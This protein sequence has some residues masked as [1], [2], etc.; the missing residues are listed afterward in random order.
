M[1]VHPPPVWPPYFEMKVDLPTDW[2][3]Y[4]EMEADPAPV[5]PLYAQFLPLL[6]RGRRIFGVSG[7]V[8]VLVLVLE[9]QRSI[10][11]T[12]TMTRTIKNL[13]G[14]C[15]LRDFRLTAS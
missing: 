5:L 4:F 13:A 2:T 15:R 14:L 6:F 1:E 11:R 12:R 10:S 7:I 3:P 9:S 8:V